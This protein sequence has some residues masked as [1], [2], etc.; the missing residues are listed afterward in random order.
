[1]FKFIL[2]VM[3]IVNHTGEITA[4]QQPQGFVTLAHCKDVADKLESVDPT[5]HVEYV[6][7][8]ATTGQ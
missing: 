2:I 3:M 1:M 8:T 6:C 5:S 4:V 7:L